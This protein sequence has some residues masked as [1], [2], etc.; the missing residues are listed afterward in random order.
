MDEGKQNVIAIFDIGKT[1][2]KLFLYDEAY[3]ILLEESNKF[4]EIKD[5]DGFPCDDL[6]E[7][8]K[9]VRERF[10]DISN[11]PRYNLLGINFS[12][13]GAS[14]V[15]IDDAGKSLTPLYNYLKPYPEKIKK[16][17]YN[18]YGEELL[19]AK[20]TAS[21]V[22]GNLNSGMQLYRLKYE[23]PEIFS[24]IKYS[25]HL[26]QY[27]SFIITSQAVSDITSI[28]CH[29]Q[30]WDFQKNQ[31]HQWVS[32]EKLHTKLAPV[33]SYK[34][35]LYSSIDKKDIVTGIGLHD[36]SA[37]LIPYL[38]LFR[39]PFIL[40]STG[41]WCISLNPFN[42]TMLTEHELQHDC[43][44]YFTYEGKPVKASRLFAG[45]EHEEQ[46]KKISA[47]FNKQRVY[48]KTIAF[49]E[50]LFKK[51]QHGNNA[52]E[53]NA[54]ASIVQPSTFSQRPLNDFESFEEAYHQLL[55]DIVQQQVASTEMVLNKTPVKKIFVDGGFG[56]NDVYMNLLALA[57]PHIKL[58][59]ADI[60]QATSL[61]AA[62]ALHE[63]VNKEQLPSNMIELKYYPGKAS[64]S[65]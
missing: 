21:P 14:L 29:T 61:G 63:H 13:Y 23:Q 10:F 30:L 4:E 22:L 15:H 55:F 28:G 46:V 24:C 7:I 64:V 2:K 50:N 45:Y 40:I 37:A 36:S 6:V 32:K 34:N 54:T 48:Y 18:H 35:I 5:E 62:L 51:L 17:F 25:L 53:M 1:N 65:I 3:N 9:W 60:A 56:K 11:D 26:P 39:E 43:L 20:E 16:Q 47:H 27:L 44:C 49:D 12:A 58:Y 57:F 52:G 59:A 41:T 38:R 33:F 19:I 31:Y 8:T 42:N